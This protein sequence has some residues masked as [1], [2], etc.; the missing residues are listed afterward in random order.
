MEKLKTRVTAIDSHIAK[1][2]TLKSID[3]RTQYRIGIF[4]EN[5]QPIVT[6]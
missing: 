4:S 6:R 2:D 5:A 1:L 3:F